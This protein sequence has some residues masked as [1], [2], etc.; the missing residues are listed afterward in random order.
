MNTIS[1]QA[2]C[3]LGDCLGCHRGTPAYCDSVQLSGLNSDGG[4][5]EYILADPRF[6]VR[7]PEG[8][9]FLKAAPLMCAGSTVY[10]SILNAKRSKG[11]IIAMIGIGGLGHLGVQFAKV[12]GYKVVAV[13]MRQPPLD[14]VSS[15]SDRHRPDLIIDAKEGVEAA[16]KQISSCFRTADGKW[17]ATGVDAAI[18]CASTI[19]SYTFSTSILAKHGTLVAVGQPSEHIPFHW[20]TFVAKDI[21]I[22]PGCL[23]N[24]SIVDNMMECV[25]R[26]EIRVE[27]KEYQLGD[28]ANLLKEYHRPNMVGKL[29]FSIN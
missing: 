27:V 25:V 20:S 1:D 8:L 26:E 6:T 17:P 15:F 19:Q 29:V 11:D 3:I 10:N 2:L 4:M 21:T 5:A 16:L 12:M 7:L 23:G 9:S 14:F 24:K 28:V 22:V 13:D 18:V